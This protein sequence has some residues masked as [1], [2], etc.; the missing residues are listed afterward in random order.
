MS[1]MNTIIGFLHRCLPCFPEHLSSKPASPL[2]APVPPAPVPL[3]AP[4][5][6]V[7]LPAPPA[8]APLPAPPVPAPA[9]PSASSTPA[10]PLPVYP[11]PSYIFIKTLG[12]A[13]HH[14]RSIL[15]GEVVGFDLES[16]DNPNRSKLSKEKK[17]QKRKDEIRDAPTF[18]IDW[19]QVE[20]FVA[21]IA[22]A[23]GAV[24]VIHLSQIAALPAEFV[25]ICESP[26]ILKVAAGIY[27]DG[28][29][30]WDNFRLNLYCVTSLGLASV[31]AYPKDL[32]PDLPY[33]NEPGLAKIVEHVLHYDLEKELQTSAW[34]SIPLS[35][36]QQEYAAAD[37]HATLASYLVIR[38]VLDGCGFVVDPKWYR[39]DIV[40]RKAEKNVL[41]KLT[42]SIVKSM[43]NISRGSSVYVAKTRPLKIMAWKLTELGS[44]ESRT[45]GKRRL[46]P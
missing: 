41:A 14:L 36:A 37:V 46:W 43:P 4:P 2:P 26:R 9:S 22:T 45:R 12:E 17:R 35:E 23:I 8:P 3:P 5:A 32:N 10:S 34:N 15:D 27:S 11:T 29:R 25:R 42:A 1:P 28:Q 40:K 38:S 18:T 20:V 31:L 19:T 33:G 24:Y 13:N 21:Q 39:Y 30:L 7:P 44:F 16:V 6:P